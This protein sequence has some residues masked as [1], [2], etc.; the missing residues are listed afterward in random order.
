MIILFW[1]L[2]AL[3]FYT[4]LGYGIL[5]YLLVKIK[6]S[7]YGNGERIFRDFAE[8]PEVT[9]LIAAWNEEDIV[10]EKM[11]NTKE[12]ICKPGKLKIVWVTD[13]ST[14][15]TNDKLSKY[16]DVT[17]L[18]D[19]A[20]R[21]KTAAINRAMHFI[22]TPLV[23]FTDANTMLNREAVSEIVRCFADL[24]VGCVAGEKRVRSGKNFN[25]SSGGEGLYWR[26]ESFLKDQDSRFF[27]AVGAA[28]ELFAIRR[29]LFK[30]M[31]TDTLLDDFVMSME[32]AGNGYKIKYCPT[33]WAQEEASLNMREEKKR[34][35]R[36][37]AGG[38]QAVWRLRALMNILKFPALA[39]QFISHRVLRWSVTPVALVIL[40]PLNIIIVLAGA[41]GIYSILL[42]LQ[43]LFWLAGLS[44]KILDDK[45]KRTGPLFIPYYFL[46]M[47]LNVLQGFLYLYKKR[48]DGTWERAARGGNKK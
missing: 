25:A 6:E 46:F 10:E 35:V 45:G 11:A 2:A 18:F 20:R 40:L 28:G 3:I 42:L 36:I 31:R 17:I 48:G 47:N 4:Y 7:F 14:D 33:A 15:S 22:N 37:A 23:I 26:Y 12:L 39:F 43:I 1:L 38:I 9:L 21:G 34:K 24:R 32:I 41:S 19:P 29:I 8:W 16:E 44:G 30:E 5:I 27:T 13:G